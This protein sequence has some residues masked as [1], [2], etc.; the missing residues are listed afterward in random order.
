MK[1]LFKNARIFVGDHTPI[2][3]GYL[4]TNE[5]LIDEIGKTKEFDEAKFDRVIDCNGNLLMPGFKNAHSHGAM[6]FYRSAC[7]DLSTHD[8]LFNKILPLEEKM[9]EKDIYYLSKVAFL[10]SVKGGITASFEY[11]FGNNEISRAAQ[12][13]GI[14]VAQLISLKPS[15]DEHY[16]VK[17]KLLSNDHNALVTYRFGCHSEYTNTKEILEVSSRL[18]H[19]L[20]IPFF[21]HVA[22]TH[23]EVEDCIKRNGMTPVKYFDSLGLFDFGGAI[24]HGIY[25]NAEDRSILKKHN[26]SVVCNPGSNSKLASGICDISQLHKDRINVA[27]GTDGP[28][29]NNSI[30]MFKEMY[31]ASVLQ[32]LLYKNP[33]KMD[34]LNVLDM[35][36]FNGAKAVGWTN[37]DILAKGK[38]ADLIMIDLNNPSM[39]PMHN[40]LKNIV[41]AGSKDVV[42]LTMINGKIIYENHDFNIDED[43]NYIYKRVNEITQDILK[44]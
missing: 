14:R 8:W 36:L 33:A 23:E 40:I 15:I 42:I 37:A 3:F 9:T 4:T 1:I 31:L 6:C 43:I 17:D 39:Q 2:F 25:L 29:S 41:Y 44:R 19:E 22:E 34:A 5:N 13:V 35:A 32:K 18:I 38:F 7:D 27:L 26:V 20:K 12:D 21:A 11:Y 24:Y 28:A 30:D 16:D 10:E